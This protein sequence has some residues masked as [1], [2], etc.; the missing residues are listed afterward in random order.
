MKILAGFSVF[1]AV[2]LFLGELARNAGGAQWWPFWLVDVVAASLLLVGGVL[3]LMRGD[4]RSR[5]ILS[6]GWGFLVAMNWMSFASHLEESLR[7]NAPIERMTYAAG[8]GL[9]ISILCLVLSLIVL[10]RASVEGRAL[11][12]GKDTAA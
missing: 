11:V 6:T 7:L 1:H 8:S 9:V 5:L 4:L 2:V 3:T 10:G 12:A